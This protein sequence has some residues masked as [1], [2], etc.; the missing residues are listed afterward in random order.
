MK[1]FF[2]L[3]FFAVAAASTAAGKPGFF[4]TAQ[5]DGIW[6]LSDPQG[7]P[8]L[9]VTAN[10]IGTE[11]SP[12]KFNLEH[13]A[14]CPLKIFPSEEA[15]AQ[16]AIGRMRSWNFNALGGYADFETYKL[17]QLPYTVAIVMGGWLGF[18]W[19]DILDP[20]S[21]KTLE[22]Q[23]IE[24][25]KAWRDDPLCIGYFTDNEQ[26]WWDESMVQYWLGVD[27]SHRLKREFLKILQE[28]YHGD[29]NAFQADF[30]VSP[31]PKSWSDLGGALS[32][33]AYAPGKRPVAADRFVELAAEEYYSTVSRILRQ[34]DPNHLLLGD[35]YASFYSQS[36]A[37]ACGKYMDVI[38]TNYNTFAKNGWIAQT[39]FDSLYALTQKP[40]MVSEFY[41]SAMQN[42]TGNR[43]QNG[44]YIIVQ[45]QKERAQGAA[46]M[47]ENLWRLPYMVG[48]HWFSWTDEPRDG[49]EDGEDFNFGLVDIYDKA[50]PE[51]TAAIG[52]ANAK[53]A[54]FH[55][56]GRHTGLKSLGN[57]AWQLSKASS[58]YGL[59][60][61]MDE[62]DHA[63]SW[64]PNPG[65]RGWQA[66]GDF[67]AAWE[68]GGLRLGTTFYD[69]TN[70]EAD[71]DEPLDA[72]RF[73]VIIQRGAKELQ[74]TMTGFGERVGPKSKGKKKKEEEPPLAPLRLLGNGPAGIKG[75]QDVY[76]LMNS[77]EIWVPAEALGGVLKAGENIGLG[78]SLKLRGDTRETYWP[79]A[80][81]TKF[82]WLK[83]GN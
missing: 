15:W 40:I 2:T 24:Q 44:P 72:P 28:T 32:S 25:T 31:I 73:S 49:R 7:K 6:W 66:S 10:S 64:L 27:N 33:V 80:P 68:E 79:T 17:K 71:P 46:N 16:S 78:L 5:K 50:Y 8:F 65:G 11:T 62:W 47:T 57:G 56:Q 36:V 19:A 14:Y 58:P 61:K 83:L 54:D 41:F 52:S 38:S 55:R 75:N 29:L 22:Q 39:F 76:S 67:Y 34:A 26:G 43:N 45:T 12:E 3:C 18:P 48:T 20:A 53:A 74:F 9:C 70:N 30:K 4:G 69:Y 35:R 59:D 37:R 82:A 1:T 23:A 77:S 51:L 21:L 13:P 42:S 63:A 81:A 60:G